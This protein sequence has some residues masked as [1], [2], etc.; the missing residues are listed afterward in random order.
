MQLVEQHDVVQLCCHSDVMSDAILSMRETG[1]LLISSIQTAPNG[2]TQRCMVSRISLDDYES[3]Y[4]RLT[5]VRGK[6]VYTT[7]R[8]VPKG[9]RRG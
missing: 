3:L 8:N 7:Y 5:I 6:P 2:F 4:G 9:A 1:W